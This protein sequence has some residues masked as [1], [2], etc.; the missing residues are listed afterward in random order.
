MKSN[1]SKIENPFKN[2]IT[3]K[4]LK[5]IFQNVILN[6]PETYTGE[7]F[8]VTT[9]KNANSIEVNIDE[10]LPEFDWEKYKVSEEN[11]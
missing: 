6:F 4:E 8:E 10:K 7:K 1:F 9:F 2:T 11:N 3:N 5:E